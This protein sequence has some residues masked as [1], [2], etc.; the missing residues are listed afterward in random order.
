MT[1]LSW[2]TLKTG[3]IWACSGTNDR[4]KNCA[5]SCTVTNTSSP[6]SASQTQKCTHAVLAQT[7]TAA[8]IKFCHRLTLFSLLLFNKRR[9]KTIKLIISLKT[10]NSYLR[11][12]SNAAQ[13]ATVH[14]INPWSL[15]N[16]Y[17]SETCCMRERRKTP[18]VMTKR[19][20]AITVKGFIQMF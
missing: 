4:T 18:S 5:S 8:C 2:I 17:I 9:Y 7:N 12:A 1:Q 14:T 19:Q 3:S 11:S 6:S 15:K 10:L 13:G 20:L 16:R